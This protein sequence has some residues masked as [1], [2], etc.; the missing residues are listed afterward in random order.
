[1][2]DPAEGPDQLVPRPQEQM[3]RVREDDLRP[4]IVQ[5]RRRQRFDRCLGA[6]GMNTGV[7][8]VPCDVANSPRRAERRDLFLS[9]KM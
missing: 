2:L 9:K 1:M 7:W 3:V 5:V 4:K 6:H 8:T